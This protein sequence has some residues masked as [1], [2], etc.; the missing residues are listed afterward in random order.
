MASKKNQWIK[1]YV[2]GSLR[3]GGYNFNRFSEAMPGGV[4]YGGTRTVT[5]FNLF[6]LGIGYPAASPGEGLL[7]VDELVVHLA[8][9][10]YLI[11]MEQGAGYD[12]VR[13]QDGLM[14]LMRPQIM[15]RYPK[16][17]LVKGGDW[18]KFLRSQ[19]TRPEEISSS[20]RESGVV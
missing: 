10:H 4:K 7:V 5:G 13:Y 12:M 1:F 19:K 2:Y 9:A 11:E 14:F 18:I 16:A 15:R 8:L 6:D 20:E 3:K 17:T